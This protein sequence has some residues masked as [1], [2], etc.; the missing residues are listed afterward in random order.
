M[1][2]SFLVEYKKMSQAYRNLKMRLQNDKVLDE[3]NEV[4]QTI[5][6]DQWIKIFLT[7]DI[8]TNKICIQVEVSPKERYNSLDVGEIEK[9]EFFRE[10]LKEQIKSLK[11]LLYLTELEFSLE[12]L[13]EEN[14]WFGTKILETEPTEEFCKLISLIN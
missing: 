4:S 1:E 13:F 3:L 8:R 2:E 10:F 5:Y 11:H 7:G 14:I 9:K 12:F 6:K